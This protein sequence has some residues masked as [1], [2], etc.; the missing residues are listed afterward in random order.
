MHTKAFEAD[1]ALRNDWEIWNEMARAASH[2]Q[3]LEEEF[4]GENKQRE[5]LE[6]GMKAAALAKDEKGIA[7]MTH[8]LELLPQA[9]S[10]EEASTQDGSKDEL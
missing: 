1:V 9:S 2:G 3:C 6:A 10:T 7:A 8:Q 4:C 5:Y